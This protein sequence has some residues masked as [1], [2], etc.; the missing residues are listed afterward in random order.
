MLTQRRLYGGLLVHIG[1]VIM[2]YGIIASSFYNIKD[3][4]VVAPGESFSFGQYEMQVG[5]LT[6]NQSQ[7]FTS[8]YAPVKVTENGKEIVTVAPERRFYNKRE[9]AWAEVAIY[10][11]LKGDLYFILASYSKPE[12][13]IGIQVV[14]EPLLVW[15]WIGCAIM[16]VG[17]VYTV[18]GRSKNA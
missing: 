8:V 12:N 4:H 18:S 14:Y 11:K 7:N 1:V 10:S 3:E 17:A 15:L 13:Y 16:C 5:E 6:V 2:A 9:E